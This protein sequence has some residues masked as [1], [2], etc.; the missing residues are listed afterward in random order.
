MERKTQDKITIA[1]I[2]ILAL[3]VWAYMFWAGLKAGMEKKEREDR[4]ADMVFIQQ[5]S[6]KAVVQPGRLGVKVMAIITSY[7]NDPAETDDTPDIT[8]S[9]Q[10]V[11]KGIVANNCLEFG[12]KVEIE[13]KTY[14]VQDR[15]AGRWGCEHF[16]VFT[17]DKAEAIKAGRQQ[18]EILIY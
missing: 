10:P 6:L 18:K 8:A 3:A 15:M 17:F 11:M 7:T 13:G 1:A 9:N 16:D 12:Q 14:E 5:N 4:R 2:I